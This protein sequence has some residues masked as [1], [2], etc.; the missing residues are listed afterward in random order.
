MQA[1]WCLQA[2]G[3][4]SS[5]D[6]AISK[7]LRELA[8]PLLCSMAHSTGRARSALAAADGHAVL[9]GALT[10]RTWQ[11]RPPAGLD[12]TISLNDR[13]YQPWSCNRAVHETEHI[14]ADLSLLKRSPT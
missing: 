8:V 13:D 1:W 12:D 10:D 14:C 4:A 2:N 3:T 9:L 6:P 7:R 11:V 5:V